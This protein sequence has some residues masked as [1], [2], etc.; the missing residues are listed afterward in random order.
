MMMKAAKRPT[1]NCKNGCTSN[2]ILIRNVT[3]VQFN[4]ASEDKSFE[5]GATE[6]GW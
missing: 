4:R 5:M 2:E 1:Y 3:L 6:S